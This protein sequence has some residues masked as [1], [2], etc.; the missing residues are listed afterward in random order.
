MV[1]PPCALLRIPDQV[2][3]R[4]IVVMP[5]LRAAEARKVALCPVGVDARAS[6]VELA[7][8]DPR[9]VEPAV[10]RIP[11]RS[12]V[13]HELGSGFTRLMMKPNAFTSALNT[14]GRGRPLRSLATTT[15]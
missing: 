12:F 13:G 9:H 8:I 5:D 3:A 14:D 7:M 10:Q 1:F 6:A 4:D 15:T 2:L 11:S